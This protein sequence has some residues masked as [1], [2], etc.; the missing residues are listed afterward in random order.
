MK[1][2]TG[3]HVTSSFSKLVCQTIGDDL[4][5][6]TADQRNSRLR[7]SRFAVLVTTSSLPSNWLMEEEEIRQDC[8]SLLPNGGANSD[9]RSLFHDNLALLLIRQL[10]SSV[11]VSICSPR[12]PSA[13]PPP[14]VCS[15]CLLDCQSVCAS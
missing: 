3:H 9:C 1:L 4:S 8:V 14:V 7:L 10:K 15:N 11:D 12:L 6:V 5:T 13:P 2:N